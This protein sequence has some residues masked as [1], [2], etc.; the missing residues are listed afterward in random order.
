MTK[1][2][3]KFLCVICLGVCLI[4]CGRE[5]EIGNSN[6]A[7]S[8]S[9][10]QK[11]NGS[12]ENVVGMDIDSETQIL[13]DAETESE[14]YCMGTQYYQGELVVLLAKRTST[15]VDIYL[16]K[17]DGKKER[18][19]EGLR[20]DESYH[21]Q[22]AVL[23]EKGNL[24]IV[25]VDEVIKINKEGVVEY[26]TSFES[27]TGATRKDFC[28]LDDGRLVIMVIDPNSYVRKLW[29]MD[30]ESGIFEEKDMGISIPQEE[31]SCLLAANGDKVWLFQ[32]DGIWEVDEEKGKRKSV[33][34]FT[35]SSYTFNPSTRNPN[36]DE[37]SDAILLED[38]SI[39]I[40]WRE[41][42]TQQGVKECLQFVSIVNREILSFRAT[43]LY[44]QTLRE[45]IAEFNKMNKKYYIV[46]EECGVN[47]AEEDF[48]NKTGIQLATGKGADIV[49]GNDMRDNLWNLIEQDI[50][51]DL[52]PYI[53]NSNLKTDEYFRTVFDNWMVGDSR[54]G[55][56][57]GASIKT[58][59]MDEEILGGKPAPDTI[60]ELA[61]ILLAYNGNNRLYGDNPIYDSAWVLKWLLQGSENL[62]GMVNWEE[63]KCDFSGELFVKLL[64][65][66]KKYGYDERNNEL[67]LLTESYATDWYNF[68]SQE[69]MLKKGLV[70]VGMFT[71]EGI[72]GEVNDFQMLAVSAASENKD[73][74]WEF[75]EFLLG[76]EKKAN[77]I[78]KDVFWTEMKDEIA[79]HIEIRDTLSEEFR[80]YP[81]D[82][83][84]VEMEKRMNEACVCPLRPEAILTIVCEEA[85]DYFSGMKSERDVIAVIE[86]RVHL[87]LEEHQ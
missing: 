38:G 43:K 84:L 4:G 16:H 36:V 41:K 60:E 18:I 80:Y 23:D 6:V 7:I 8:S 46:M 24:F 79:A 67:P 32:W 68:V 47:E 66:A 19:F 82:E 2:F 26:I 48:I 83:M 49:Y 63:S 70:T 1:S 53:D 73:G 54:Y 78:K 39:E 37:I 34:E 3:L 17:S 30:T 21:K 25:K 13:W 29:A 11:Q 74:A 9:D 40:L 31:G 64:Q 52:T 51:L 69:Q 20:R 62:W 71:D 33:M 42:D 28:L 72:Q 75:I 45:L 61:D 27:A 55:I 5:N 76:S 12:I 35:G 58:Y 65:V 59:V 86:N 85:G 44:D 77:A 10:E 81:T 56:C 57:I 15:G 50:F 22:A 87:Y 14:Y